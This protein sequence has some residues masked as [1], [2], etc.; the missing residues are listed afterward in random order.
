MLQSGAISWCNC[1]YIRG[2]AN[3]TQNDRDNAAA[4]V[5]AD[6]AVG[7]PINPLTQTR[8]R[9]NRLRGYESS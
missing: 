4:V 5:W 1:P 8:M 6:T 3:V 2:E 9:R 7:N